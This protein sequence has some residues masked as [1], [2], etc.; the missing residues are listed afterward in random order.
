MEMS[1]EELK[2]QVREAEESNEVMNFRQEEP[3][4]TKIRVEDKPKNKYELVE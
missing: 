2:K 1:I 3:Q 4:P